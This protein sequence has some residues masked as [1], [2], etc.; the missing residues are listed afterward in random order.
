[1]SRLRHW[2]VCRQQQRHSPSERV[3]FAAY[4]YRRKQEKWRCLRGGPPRMPMFSLSHTI[5]LPHFLCPWGATFVVLRN[6]ETC[7]NGDHIDEFRLPSTVCV[8]IRIVG[9]PCTELDVL[10]H[11]V[12][13]FRR[14]LCPLLVYEVIGAGERR[15]PVCFVTDRVGCP[16]AMRKTVRRS[17]RLFQDRVRFLLTAIVSPNEPERL[18]VHIF[19]KNVWVIGCLVVSHVL[20]YIPF[21]HF[22]DR[23]RTELSATLTAMHTD[24]T[25]RVRVLTIRGNPI[26]SM[27]DQWERA[28]LPSS[29]VL[30]GCYWSSERFC[31]EF[32]GQLGS[33]TV[34]WALAVVIKAVRIV[35]VHL[36]ASSCSKRAI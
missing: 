35:V 10:P 19:G 11:R 27:D 7:G 33:E 22:M 15:P 30:P 4:P 25:E 21:L 3:P 23:L 31:F 16:T 18:P 28:F 26:V 34:R 14:Y 17:G 32:F 2:T 36:L 29:E 24:F 5:T 8:A 12:P 20:G 9:I 13:V 6:K 1:M